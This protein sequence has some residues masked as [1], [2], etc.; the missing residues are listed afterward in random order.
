M[1]D[2]DEA[3]NSRLR[4]ARGAAGFRVA[5]EHWQQQ[6]QRAFVLEWRTEENAL[7]AD[8]DGGRFHIHRAPDGDYHLRYVWPRGGSRGLT[9]GTPAH[10]HQYTMALI[11]GGGPFGGPLPSE[12]YVGPSLFAW[13]DSD[14][15]DEARVQRHGWGHTFRHRPVAGRRYLV[16]VSPSGS[17]ALG[18]QGEVDDV[19]SIAESMR[20]RLSPYAEDLGPENEPFFVR[21]DGVPVRLLYAAC[22]A[23]LGYI[24]L[25]DRRSRATE[26]FLVLLGADDI[27]LVRVLD[28]EAVVLARGPGGALVGTEVF[29]ETQVSAPQHLILEPTSM[30]PAAVAEAIG[31]MR[32]MAPH[33]REHLVTLARTATGKTGMRSARELVWLVAVAHERG[34]RERIS[35]PLSIVLGR[36]SEAAGIEVRPC[37]RAL[38]PAL[39]WLHQH[40]PIF[41]PLGGPP[42]RWGVRIDLLSAPDLRSVEWFRQRRGSSGAGVPVDPQRPS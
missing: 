23:F 33:M 10:L 18:G 8:F 16:L 31:R 35:G 38:R 21:V 14:L 5:R 20:S 13:M 19:A 39:Q 1:R 41:F 40:S 36:L 30:A 4:L 32:C 6:Q 12:P 26:V 25:P 15:P 27:A 42:G 9:S 11:L 37:D 3:L 2:I 22:P 24:M 29:P 34:Y 17:F 28:D 7:V